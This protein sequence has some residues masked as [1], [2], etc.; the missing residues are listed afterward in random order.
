MSE[1]ASFYVTGGTLRADAPCYVKRQADVELLAALRRREFAY[2]LTSRQMGKSSL[3]VRAAAELRQAG[4]R[5]AV[6]DITAL[7]QSL[8]QEQWYLGLL[9]RLGSQLGATAELRAFWETHRELGPVQRWFAALEAVLLPV[10]RDETAESER[11]VSERGPLPGL[12]IFIDEIDAVRSLPFSTDEFFAA[13]RECYNRR[14]DYPDFE[15]ITFCL[16]GVASPSELIQDPRTTPF[17]I[18][19]RVQL[20]DFS[21]AEA[22]PLA[23]GLSESKPVQSQLLQ[24]VLY[25]TGGHP[26]LTQQLC[27]TI[28]ERSPGGSLTTSGVDQVCEQLFL[29]AG[30][31][32]RDDNLL[33]VRA[34]L[35]RTEGDL[36]GR[37]EELSR[38]ITGVR[39][40]D[41]DESPHVE[42]LRLSGVVRMDGSLLRIRNRIYERAF[43][44]RWIRAQMP[45]AELR[46]QQAAYR[47]GVVRATAIAGLV[48][49]LLGSFAARAV[50]SE[51]HTQGLLQ[52]KG[53]LLERN[54]S[55]LKDKERT[56]EKLQRAIRA[57]E[58]ARRAAQRQAERAR[59]AGAGER[60]QREAAQREER[61]ALAA[62]GRAVEQKL[63]AERFRS[64]AETERELNRRQLVRAQVAAGMQQTLDG[65][66]FGALL[67]YVQALQLDPSASVVHRMRIGTLLQQTPQLRGVW[68]MREPRQMLFS[69]DGTR[70]LVCEQHSAQ[71]FS[72]STLR[73]LGEPQRFSTGID[74]VEFS[75]DG[76]SIAFAR[77]SA[78]AIWEVAS[79]KLIHL[80]L[81]PE[82]GLLCVHFSPDSRLLAV[83]SADGSVRVFEVVT[84]APQAAPLRHAG[85]VTA[86]DFSP[87]GQFLATHSA[88]EL[89][90]WD[91]RKSVQTAP[92]A[93]VPG[94]WELHFS[95]D[96][97]RL[98]VR[99]WHTRIWDARR[100]VLQTVVPGN[101]V[102]SLQFDS[103]GKYVASADEHLLR[104]FSLENGAAYG[105]PLTH[106]VPLEETFLGAD[107]ALVR[108]VTRDGML[109]SWDAATGKLV[110]EPVRL[111]ASLRSAR[112]SP[113][114]T[115]LATTDAGGLVRLWD[116]M[117]PSLSARMLL[118]TPTGSA[119][120]LVPGH[121]PTVWQTDGRKL[122]VWELSPGVKAIATLSHDRKLG[123]AG[124]SPG[125]G[126]AVTV[127]EQG[128]ATFWRRVGP[129]FTPLQVQV[130]P[131]AAVDVSPNGQ[132]C[133][134]Y[135]HDLSARIYSTASGRPISGLLSGFHPGTGTFSP[136]SRFLV[137]RGSGGIRIMCHSGPGFVRGPELAHPEIGSVA[138]SSGSDRLVTVGGPVGIRIWDLP[139]GKRL[140]QFGGQHVGD[141][142]ALS[143]DG[144]RLATGGV[145]QNVRIWSMESAQELTP[146]LRHRA[147]VNA[148]AFDPSGRTLVTCSAG[149]VR[150]WDTA[151]GEPLSPP[152]DRFETRTAAF[153]PDGRALYLVG[154]GGLAR[155]E[156][157]LAKLSIPELREVAGVLSGRRVDASHQ[158]LEATTGLPGNRARLIRSP[159][160]VSIVPDG[161]AEEPAHRTAAVDCEQT[162]RWEAAIIHLNWLIEHEP[163]RFDYYRRRARA[164]AESGKWKAAAADF[165]A[166]LQI[167]S[168]NQL[169]WYHL[170]LCELELGNRSA[171]AQVC[172]ELNRVSDESSPV[173]FLDLAAWTFA[174]APQTSEG[175]KAAFGFT[176]R[177]LALD[178]ENVNY[179]GTQGALLYRAGRYS[180]ARDVLSHVIEKGGGALD[181]W[182]LAAAREQL[183]DHAGAVKDR[184]EALTRIKRE[185]G[186]RAQN[187]IPWDDR[188][189]VHVLQMEAASHGTDLCNPGD[190]R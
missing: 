94:V 142:L 84:G 111:G 165:R 137:L 43:D 86:L 91:W 39:V 168:G 145:D 89:R 170:A 48:I 92:P 65:D 27:R 50:T 72:A 15:R 85:S 187:E 74:A 140:H 162:G 135:F 190:M 141:R 126:C 18:G 108:T 90:L 103:G 144:S 188:A 21:H 28:V 121:R 124:I 158:L 29:T 36:T 4:V 174:L 113:D 73:P 128:T 16:L 42:V 130:K 75:P 68:S 125:A 179:L 181:Y 70:L 24:R 95:R 45:G 60:R 117:P 64:Q 157:P 22:L 49:T 66:P 14:A 132:F 116:T 160:P 133:I 161:V 176:K 150:V 118:E 38:A 53:R 5:V 172:N 122:G 37:L 57:R 147:A 171:Y 153:Q 83:G 2:V 46:R 19:R 76:H 109:R 47:Q 164:F 82:S 59:E 146:P 149:A 148:L 131:A 102:R 12:V 25:W 58:V 96:G 105:L 81:Q 13:I 34:R 123:C 88:N 41:E 185:F 106:E 31:R 183:G 175:C 63:T 56:L 186:A 62:K 178:P 55:L 101:D 167:D 33:H 119:V 127:D 17:N 40:R 120:Q 78:V 20:Q 32:Q 9:S 166:V 143:P 26:Y 11:G 110:V 182:F 30:A 54:E 177:L 6:L 87:D 173:P 134:L 136:N 99:E 44:R 80:P 67:W 184:R 10:L 104:I 112:F 77:D 159:Q 61:I 129:G 114:G 169:E 154:P 93:H 139:T 156:L 151:T 97:S 163:G 23:R 115:R 52:E 138:M 152:D 189:E 98:V 100:L 1:G 155:A 35:L 107:G 7:G 69:P 8:S 180:E 51:A 79:R 71:L 3:M